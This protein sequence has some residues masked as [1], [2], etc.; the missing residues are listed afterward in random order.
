MAPPLPS[1]TVPAGVRVLAMPTFLVSKVWVNTPVSVPARLPV[2]TVG[3]GARAR[4]RV[5]D[6]GVARAVTVIG[7]ATMVKF[8]GTKVIV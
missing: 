4:R 6:L 1:L 2:V 8:A 5:V 7:R 3:I